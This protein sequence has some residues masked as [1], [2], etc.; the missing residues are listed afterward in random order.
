MMFLHS[1]MER[2]LFS[3]IGRALILLL[4]NLLFF[5]H[6]IDL[7]VLPQAVIQANANPEIRG[8]KFSDPARN[9]Q[10]GSPQQ[11]ISLSPGEVIRR[12]LVGGG[13][14]IF[15]VQLSTGQYLR[16]IIEQHGISVSASLLRP[17][18]SQI[19]EM[20][21]PAG[22]H[23]PLYISIIAD[24]SGDYRLV[25]RSFENWA[26][27]GEYEVKIE[28]LRAATP[29]DAASVE[30]E[31]AF[32]EGRRLYRVTTRESRLAAIKK[33]EEALKY[34]KGVGNHHW[35]ALTLYN[36]AV[37]YRKLGK[38]P[39]AENFFRESLTVSLD[40]HDWRLRASVLNDFGLNYVDR[41]MYQEALDVINE[42]LTIFT[43]HQD[44]RGRASAF[45]NI[46]LTY[47]NA[48]RM[49][50]AEEFYQKALP[51]RQ[52]ENDQAG[53]ANL[54]NN[55]GG[56][57]DVLGEPHEALEYYSKALKVWQDMDA[58]GQLNDRDL[59]P[60]GFNNVAVAYD[61]LGEWQSALE[62]YERA[63]KLSHETGNSQR[64]AATLDNIG[65]LYNG[66]GDPIS[67][68]Q[69]Y[70]DALALLQGKAPILEASVL[71]HIGQLSLSQGKLDDALEFFKKALTISQSPLRRAQA[72]T[73]IGYAYAQQENPRKAI[74]SYEEA[75]SLRSRTGDRRGEAVTLQKRGEAYALLGKPT[76]ALA[77]FNRALSLYRVVA[78]QRGEATALYSIARIER[79]RN[80]TPQ[81]LAHSEEAI[82]IIESLRTKVSSHELRTSY[83]ATQQNYYELYID[84]NMRLYQL[85]HSPKR[86]EAAL[87]ASERSRARDLIDTLVEAQA[88][89]TQ[90]VDQSLLER[91]REVQQKLNAKAQAQMKLL[92]EQHTDEQARALAQEI[93]QLIALYKSLRAQIRVSSPK[94]AHLTQPQTL[95]LQEMQQLLDD[96]T[97]MLEYSLGEERSYLWLLSNSSIVGSASL[98]KRSEIEEAARRLYELLTAPQLKAGETP[99][100]RQRRISSAL[101]QYPSQASALSQMLLG[102]VAGQLGKKR[103]IIVGDGVLNYLPFNA[104]PVPLSPSP[105][106]VETEGGHPSQANGMTYLIEEHEI[107]GLPSASALALMRSELASRRAAP[108]AVAVLADPVFDQGD[109]RLRALQGNRAPAVG[110]TPSSSPQTRSILDNETLRSGLDLQPLPSTRREAEAIRKVSPPGQSLLA[111]DFEANRSTVLGLQDG[112]FRI[113]HFATHGILNSEHPE[114]SAIVLSL[115][116]SNGVNQNGFLRLHDIYNLKLPVDL[117]V[118]SACSTGL[119]RVI[120]G[121]GLIGLTRGFMYAGSPRIISSLW[122]VDDLATAVMMEKFYQSVF[123]RGM[124]SA[125]ALRQAQIEM[126]KNKRWQSPFYW[127]GFVFQG[128]WRERR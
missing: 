62:N 23:G 95:S 11:I 9:S 27:A 118:L 7:Q 83:F 66:L 123:K 33:Y 75:L 14:Q 4:F 59:L 40:E 104:L 47:A 64:E 26:N 120:R 115:F 79:D 63:L 35:E 128:E 36:M 15:K 69:H 82:N 12:E 65:E 108:M 126:L 125:A 29:T 107:V 6:D 93:D 94:Y 91:E 2:S 54:L 102:P 13:S 124:P 98:P 77:D 78:D 49:H 25:V 41:G 46:G 17:D 32:V 39:T 106:P 45:N 19:V 97:L 28:E 96:N 80:D 70:E 24:A 86:L 51:L 88:D 109:S 71:I 44:R 30:A 58:R 112:R 31:R 48:G 114:L 68:K 37:T 111:L 61:E 34:W 127:A 89:I 57:H 22:P 20:D 101:A 87:Q 1:L 90:G 16:V 72:L 74:E 5:W 113:V 55:I 8:S 60:I 84:L 50:L 53:V 52:A 92:N 56:Y 18:G 3:Q 119:G 38:L 73:N 105:A 117:V 81:A 42:A 76:E 67:A 43:E 122:R 85:D 116:D 10:S 100:E 21:N 121:E 110:N 103:L 99:A